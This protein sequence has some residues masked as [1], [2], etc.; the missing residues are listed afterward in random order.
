MTH[1]AT[2]VHVR[3]G[4]SEL[5]FARQ[6]ALRSPKDA[7]TRAREAFPDPGASNVPAETEGGELAVDASGGALVS[8][9]ESRF[10]PAFGDPSRGRVPH[11][12]L[13]GP[14]SC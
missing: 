11:A 10:A 13:A 9:D 6:P 1:R 7:R 14:E 8:Q 2:R 12:L 3:V 5:W 4:G